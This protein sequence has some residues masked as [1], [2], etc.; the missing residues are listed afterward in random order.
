M[1]PAKPVTVNKMIAL[2]RSWILFCKVNFSWA[3]NLG[4]NGLRDDIGDTWLAKDMM[5]G[6]LFEI[7]RVVTLEDI[8]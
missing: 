8:L 4:F 3:D 6:E 1:P 2:Q 5:M 7:E